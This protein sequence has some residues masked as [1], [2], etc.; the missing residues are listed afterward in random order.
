MAPS[1][2]T[3]SF[4]ILA[5][6]FGNRPQRVG[7]SSFG[8]GTGTGATNFHVNRNQSNT[9]ALALS[10]GIY[11]CVCVCQDMRVRVDRE[12]VW[13]D[14]WGSGCKVVWVSLWYFFWALTR[15]LA[16][17]SC[18]L[19]L[20]FIALI[21]MKCASLSVFVFFFFYFLVAFFFYATLP[22][23][24]VFRSIFRVTRCSPRPAPPIS[25]PVQ[26]GFL[27]MAIL[28]IWIAGL[29]ALAPE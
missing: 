25:C 16:N 5:Q 2:L 19:L 29:D 17:S 8:T 7:Q 3:Y 23:G 26:I 21:N 18:R 20:Y 13:V 4:G 27:F 6:G 12:Y 22:F 15:Y 24:I 9:I 1:L 28:L 10:L 14:C 11:V